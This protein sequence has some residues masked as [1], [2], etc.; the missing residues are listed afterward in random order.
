MSDTPERR[1]LALK[2]RCEAL[3]KEVSLAQLQ[4]EALEREEARLVQE[5]QDRFGC[6]PE[7]LPALDERLS[8][9]IASALVEAESLLS[10][11]EAA[12]TGGGS[13]DSQLG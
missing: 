13:V 6:G 7:D 3:Q 11:V 8:R 9:E 4:L 12:L 1:L 10:Q 2:E 5:C